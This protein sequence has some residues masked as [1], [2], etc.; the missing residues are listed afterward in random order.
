MVSTICG[1]V[2]CSVFFW[3]ILK[4]LDAFFFFKFVNAKK[5]P[6][7]SKFPAVDMQ[8]YR[9]QKTV[10]IMVN[11][12]TLLI[13]IYGSIMVSCRVRQG[14][15]FAFAYFGTGTAVTGRLDAHLRQR[16]VPQVSHK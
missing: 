8:T 1:A 15:A 12:P 4:F 5:T 6:D 7:F 9:A 3:R 16:E 13:G 11:R 10:D 2:S 14:F